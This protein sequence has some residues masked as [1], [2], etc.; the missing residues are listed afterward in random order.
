MPSTEWLSTQ[1][2]NTILFTFW[3]NPKK[4]YML[5]FFYSLQYLEQFHIIQPMAY[6]CL[7][8]LNILWLPPNEL[9]KYFTCCA[10]TYKQNINLL[11]GW[12]TGC[13]W[14]FSELPKTL[15]HAMVTQALSSNNHKYNAVQSKEEVLILNKG[16]LR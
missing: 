8:T 14:Q 6:I 2:Y 1:N 15:R 11:I 4:L 3:T 13:L 9:R 7:W 12:Y 16:Q 10:L 5:S